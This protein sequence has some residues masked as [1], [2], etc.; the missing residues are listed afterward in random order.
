MSRVFVV[1]G[2]M[3]MRPAEYQ[4]LWYHDGASKF[5]GLG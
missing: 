1:A 2:D 3:A 4:R 5:F